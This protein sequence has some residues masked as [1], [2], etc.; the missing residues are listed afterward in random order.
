MAEQEEG[1]GWRGHTVATAF[2]AACVAWPPTQDTAWPPHT[3]TQRTEPKPSPQERGDDGGWPD[4]QGL[5]AL[6]LVGTRD[7]AAQAQDGGRW[8]P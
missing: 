5:P 1:L 2:S 4:A 3:L 6:G 8:W 7:P